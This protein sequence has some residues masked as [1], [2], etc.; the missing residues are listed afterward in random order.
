M[1]Q[2]WLRRYSVLVAVCAL[3]LV[4]AG[5]LVTS[6]DA[7][8]SIPDWPLAYG[9]LVPPLEGGIRFEFAHRM[10]AA[11]VALLTLILAIWVQSI[12]TRR[13]LRLVAWSAF[14]TVIAQALLGGAAVKFIDPKPVSIAHACLAQLCFGIIVAVSA[15]LFL[16]NLPHNA[17]PAPGP[18]PLIAAAALLVQ[19][20]LGAA[21]RHNVTSV[22]PHIVGAV[23]SVILVMWA[24]L[25]ILMNHMENVLF[26]RSA[27]ALLSITFSQVFLGLGAYMSRLATADAPQ[28]MPLMIWF[29]VAHVAAGSLAFGAAVALALIVYRDARPANAMLAHGGMAA[30]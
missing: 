23:V 24:G 19:T 10:L 16:A 15:S 27:M 12:E 6:N 22:V 13:W 8:L 3:L 11:A 29:T 7:A 17:T 1:G 21:L 30:A 25:Q 18:A 4:I 9:K 5:G 28:P 20:G 2:V 26:R 14:A